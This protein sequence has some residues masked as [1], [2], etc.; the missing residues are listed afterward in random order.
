MTPTHSSIA[1]KIGFMGK[2]AFTVK[3]KLIWNEIGMYAL[4]SAF[5]SD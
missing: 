2:G 1:V 4:F 3:K 5:I